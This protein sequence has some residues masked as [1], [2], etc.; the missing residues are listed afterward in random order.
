MDLAG[1]KE[2][3]RSASPIELLKRIKEALFVLWSEAVSL[4]KR[5]FGRFSGSSGEAPQ[6]ESSPFARKKRLILFGLGGATVLLFGLVIA[7]VVANARPKGTGF[8]NVAAGL[9]IP[10]EEFFS[11]SEP[12]FLPGFLPEREP[13]RFW[14]LDDIRQYW[15]IPGN[16]D[17]WLEEIKSTVD[18]LMDGVP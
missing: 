9:S 7:F 18:S 4:P 1:L 10:I 13:K 11:P 12:D 5:L 2:K 6:D 15:K 14:S 17:W 3:L 16:S 8:S